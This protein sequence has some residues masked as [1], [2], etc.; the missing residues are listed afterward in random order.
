MKRSSLYL[1]LI[2]LLFVSVSTGVLS[3]TEGLL[4]YFPFDE[5]NGDI[6]MDMSGNGHDAEINGARWIDNG[7][8]NGALEFR[9][10][11]KGDIVQV[12]NNKNRGS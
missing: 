8:V 7:K 10:V 2:A 1:T 9:G 3:S 5:G 12:I 11:S 6:A 4:L